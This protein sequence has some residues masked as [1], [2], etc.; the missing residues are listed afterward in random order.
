MPRKATLKKPST[1]K[2][3]GPKRVKTSKEPITKVPK[4]TSKAASPA[5]VTS[6]ALV[7]I[8]RAG[9]LAA[10]TALVASGAD[11][12][13]SDHNGTTS[14]HA[15]AKEGHEPIVRFLLADP[16]IIVNAKDKKGRTAVVVGALANIH[17]AALG[18]LLDDPRA[19]VMMKVS[20]K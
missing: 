1:I 7:R 11:I 2:R 12:N 19:D 15:A 10:F 3:V 20:Y 6:K 9:D 5:S 18:L 16:R 17:S 8:A 14:L 13:A 4:V